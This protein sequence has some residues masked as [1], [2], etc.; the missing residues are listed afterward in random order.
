MFTTKYRGWF[1]NGHFGKPGC[2]WVSADGLRGGWAK[3]FLGAKRAITK[4]LKEGK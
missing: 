2:Y 1:I 3:T 4:A